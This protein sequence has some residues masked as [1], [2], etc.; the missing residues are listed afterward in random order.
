MST[1]ID[2]LDIFF[3]RCCWLD[4]CLD[5]DLDLDVLGLDLDVGGLA[6]SSSSS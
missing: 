2:F 1:S 6:R 4:L 3:R 5:F